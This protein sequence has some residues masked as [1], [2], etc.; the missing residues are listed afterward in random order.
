MNWK[1]GLGIGLMFIGLFVVVTN[2]FITGAVIGFKPENYLGL[3]GVVL[4]MIGVFLTT[5]GNVVSDLEEEAELGA[6]IAVYEDRKV[7]N[8][9]E[10]RRYFMRDPF[11]FFSFQDI[12]LGDFRKVYNEVIRRDQNLLERAREVY[13]KR[14]LSI[15]QTRKPNAKTAEEFLKILYDGK[16]PKEE[17]PLI[18]REEREEIKNAFSVGWNTDFNGAQRGILR[19][20]DLW[21]GNLAGGHLAIYPTNNENLRVITS[22]TPS[23]VR[24]GRNTASQIIRLLKKF[25]EK[26][27]KTKRS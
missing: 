16:L 19:K 3:F 5:V 7:S 8:Q 21:Y 12:C 15:S 2:A 23:D 6:K 27:G 17:M 18:T 1:R 14:L 4:F 22:S 25:R 9:N 24:T 10:Y 11:G 13:G 26:T 20:Y